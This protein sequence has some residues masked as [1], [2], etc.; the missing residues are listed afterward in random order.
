M[1]PQYEKDIFCASCRLDE[2]IPD[3]S[4]EQNRNLWARIENAK[5]RLVY[6]LIRLSLPVKSKKEDPQQGLAFRFLSDATNPM[7]GTSVVMTGHNQGIV[8]LNIA[9][10]DD[11][12]RETIRH[13]MKEPF[14]TLLG[15]FRHEIGHY[16]WGRLVRDTKFL[17]PYRHL[18]GN[19]QG[20]YTQALN[21]YYKSGAPANWQEDYI[22][23]YATA[24][25]WED[26]AE[27]WAH[28]MHLQDALEIATDFGLT[29]KRI[30][31]DPQ[32][33]NDKTWLS[34][35]RTTFEGV[36]GSWSELAVSLNSFIHSMG[37]PDLYP[38][39]LSPAVISKLGF[40]YEVIGASSTRAGQNSSCV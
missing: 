35:K 22:S 2:M 4:D 34:S 27:T 37:L 29:G 21:Q 26:W 40:I 11:A 23:A 15:H 16:Y 38:F 6:S 9:E 8:T 30:L 33:K 17:E 31:L 12:K 14:R 13:L 36:F 7:G 10:A 20:D 5:R 19:E 24:H 28:F 3:L 18:F 39:A 25:P 1:I 32:D